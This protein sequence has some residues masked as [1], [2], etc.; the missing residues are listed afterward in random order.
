MK[1]V[2]EES[3]IKVERKIFKDT[4]EEVVVLMMGPYELQLLPVARDRLIIELEAS[5][6]APVTNW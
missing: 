4:G 3:R 6:T 2:T 1:V 5:K